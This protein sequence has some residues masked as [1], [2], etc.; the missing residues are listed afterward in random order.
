M[1]LL[2]QTIGLAGWLA[3]TFAAA[4]LGAMASVRA[5]SFYL[6]LELPRWAPPPWLFGPVW[7]ALYLIIAIAAWMVWRV[8]GFRQAGFALGL[9]LV[10]LV[11]NALWTSLFF[12]WR[13]GAVAFIEILILWVLI[14]ALIVAFWRLNKVAALLLAP[15]FAWVSFAA[16]L[17][18]ATWTLNP[19]T[20]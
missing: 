7:S 18:Y 1:T 9:F 12:S 13:L 6:S 14:A 20:L 16:V 4:A 15:Y 10:Q 5:E 8:Y 17:T 11:A 19:G 2:K 3:A